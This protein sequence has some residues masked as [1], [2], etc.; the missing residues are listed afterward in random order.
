M[1]YQSVGTSRFYCNILEFL[2]STGTAIDDIFRTLPVN[3]T[4][5]YAGDV[6]TV[7][8]GLF[9]KNVFVAI[10]GH[11]FA[12]E[13]A[14]FSLYDGSYTARVAPDDWIVNGDGGDSDS[15]I[16]D[17]DGFTI[18]KY[19]ALETNVVA[20]NFWEAETEQADRT[21]GSIIIGTFYDMPHSP[22][23]NLTMTREY[24]GVK[25]IETKGGASLSNDFG[26]SP[27]KWGDKAAWQLGDK[28]FSTGGR[29]IWDL[30]FS[31]LSDSAVFPDNPTELDDEDGIPQGF[32]VDDTTPDF[33][34][35]VVK[36][37]NG[38]QL[39]FIF[40]P[41]EGNSDPFSGFAICKFDMKSFSFQQT[42][43]SLYQCKVRI[44]E[45][46]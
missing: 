35:E 13:T 18:A 3:P 31:Y 39:P 45:V 2:A 16:A 29:R 11:K 20:F 46:W 17:Y 28:D 22:D 8:S 36:K 5:I 1:A 9:T 42:A 15:T 38:G 32:E 30:S 40:Q 14:H 33:I 41:D 4:K 12:S 27:P 44:R 26:S 6:N 43:P 25:T 23:L 24:G 7:P 21:A 10:L 34:S 19:P 37:C